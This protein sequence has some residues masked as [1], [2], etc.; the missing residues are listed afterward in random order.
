MKTRTLTILSALLLCASA[1]ATLNLTITLPGGDALRME[2]PDGA[3]VAVQSSTNIVRP[4]P[5]ALP[6]WTIKA[7][8]ANAAVSAVTTNMVVNAP[9]TL[10]KIGSAAYLC[11]LSKTTDPGQFTAAMEAQAGYISA[12]F[13]IVFKDAPEADR[14]EV[15][16]GFW[17]GIHEALRA[18]GLNGVV[19]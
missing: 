14:H 10:R 8:Q 16:L 11:W 7:R 15:L 6:E 12:Q 13:M 18:R 9:E 19:P 2:L 4:P 1:Q 3:Q 5:T 17:L